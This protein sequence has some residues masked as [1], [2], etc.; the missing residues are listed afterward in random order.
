MNKKVRSRRSKDV[1]DIIK[2][3]KEP[4]KIRQLE[5]RS[6]DLGAEIHR[7]ECT[8]AAAPALI[9]RQRLA[10]IDTLPPLRPASRSTTR[11]ASGKMPLHKQR[12][13]RRRHVALLIELAVV[14]SL[15]G[16]ALGWMNQWFHWWGGI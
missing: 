10:T 13:R 3:Q 2:P 6:R 1:S 9:R 15:L 5:N 7:L 4:A 8:I 14:L 11:P 16:A 12:E